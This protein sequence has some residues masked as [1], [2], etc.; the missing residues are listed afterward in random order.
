MEQKIKQDVISIGK[1][2]RRI[3]IVKG[4]GQTELVRRLQLAGI[5]MT[6]ETLVK[7]ERGIQH[8]YAS[9]LRAIRDIL[10]TTYEELL[11]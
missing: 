11:K 10:D 9:Q 2:I 7:I 8:V 6:R 3:R 4:I 5:E 1:N